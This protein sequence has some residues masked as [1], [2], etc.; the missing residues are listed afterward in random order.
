MGNCAVPAAE[1]NWGERVI[2]SDDFVRR[3]IAEIHGI[4]REVGWGR[5]GW[6]DVTRLMAKILLG[7]A[8]SIVNYDLTRPSVSAI[9]AT[10]VEPEYLDSYV[11][12][13]V[14]RN[15]WFDYWGN[16]P[17]GKVGVTE[18]D[19]PSSTFSD[20]EF[21]CDWLSR[22]PHL[23]AG[24]GVRID[25]DPR[26]TI[27]IAWNYEV[28]SAFGYDTPAAA[29]LEGTRNAFREAVQSAHMLGERLE[30]RSRLGHLIEHI[31][32]AAML[33][34][35]DRCVRE[36]N[37][38]ATKA[39]AEGS[40]LTCADNRLGVRGCQPQKRLDDM[41]QRVLDGVIPEETETFIIGQHVISAVVTAAPNPHASEAS[42]LVPPVPLALVVMKRLAGGAVALDDASLRAA[43][44]LSAG[45]CRLCGLLLNGYSIAE[46]ST[47]LGVTEGTVRQRVKAIFQKTG[48]H[49][50][51]ELIARL[52]GF[53]TT[54][55]GLGSENATPIWE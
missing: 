23:Q 15:P 8:A 44:G 28:A 16:L 55:G 42:L 33:V 2:Q 25:L 27:F 37:V 54:V 10:G 3:S 52:A 49:R 34:T 20:T 51:G 9:F 6:E 19:Y 50:Q 18:R 46:A 31:D 32:G 30:R 7:S 13:Y 35:R 47:M 26:K 24:A 1:W 40:V 11:S 17:S 4:I 53:T 45:E 22:Q 39:F 43:Y 21:Y 12:Y 48:T 29:I 5:A 41:I 38:R 14:E 36:A